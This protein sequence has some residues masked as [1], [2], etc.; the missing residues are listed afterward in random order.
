[1]FNADNIRSRA[2]GRQGFQARGRTLAETL[3]LFSISGVATDLSMSSF[4]FSYA[5]DYRLATW[6]TLFGHTGK[7]ILPEI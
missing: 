6:I 3:V 2:V 7:A 5:V 4:E 1:L